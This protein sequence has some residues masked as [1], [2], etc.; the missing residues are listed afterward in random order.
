MPAAQDDTSDESA[1]RR[2]CKSVPFHDTS[3][4][5]VSVRADLH[6]DEIEQDEMGFERVNEKM[7]Q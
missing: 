6:P 2:Q 4:P 3:S 5:E 7:V 1:H